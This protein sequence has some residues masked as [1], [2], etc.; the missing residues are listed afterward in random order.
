MAT[1]LCLKK[2]FCMIQL[3]SPLFCCHFD[4]QGSVFQHQILSMD[5][6]Q[7][8]DLLTQTECIL[9]YAG[10]WPDVCINYTLICVDVAFCA[11]WLSVS[12]Q[13]TLGPLIS[14]IATT[15]YQLVLCLLLGC[16]GV[17]IIWCAVVGWYI[18]KSR[19]QA[20]SQVPQNQAMIFKA[21]ILLLLLNSATVLFYAITAPIITSV[22]HCLA[23]LLGMGLSKLENCCGHSSYQL[24]SMED[25]RRS[26]P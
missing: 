1:H 17:S 8:A 6:C 4:S 2:C 16:S 19:C 25:S 10:Y 23:L 15:V 26:P 9:T 20:G 18:H 12:H 22:A 13:K 3:A 21:E 14:F 5:D 7:P 11:W 24:A